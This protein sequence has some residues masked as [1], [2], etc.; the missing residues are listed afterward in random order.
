MRATD[1][2]HLPHMAWPGLSITV[3]TGINVCVS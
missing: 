1:L 2:W 3:G